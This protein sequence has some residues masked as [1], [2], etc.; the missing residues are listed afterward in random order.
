MAGSKASPGEIRRDV[1]E[2]VRDRLGRAIGDGSPSALYKGA[3]SAHSQLSR[4]LAR[5]DKTKGVNSP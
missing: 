1:I 4:E 2:R 3:S 5:T